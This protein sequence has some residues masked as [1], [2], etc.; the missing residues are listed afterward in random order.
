MKYTMDKSLVWMR[1]SI[2]HRVYPRH[3]QTQHSQ[4]RMWWFGVEGWW[5]GWVH[6]KIS[7]QKVSESL[8]WGA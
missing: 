2:M 4:G 7:I 3:K 6:N 5:G 1:K 8:Y